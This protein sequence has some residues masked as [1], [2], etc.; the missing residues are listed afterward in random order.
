MSENILAINHQLN[1]YCVVTL[2]NVSFNPFNPNW[3]MPQFTNEDTNADN[4]L[5]KM[6]LVSGGPR[7]QTWTC[8]AIINIPHCLSALTDSVISTIY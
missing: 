8:I 2:L 7:V 3:Y 5:S 4:K 6:K 1:V